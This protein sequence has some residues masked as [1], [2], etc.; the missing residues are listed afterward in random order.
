MQITK[1]SKNLIVN[2]CHSAYFKWTVM[3][4]VNK[5]GYNPFCLY[6]MKYEQIIITG[7]M[8]HSLEIKHCS[9]Y[10]YLRILKSPN[11]SIKS[12]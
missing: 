9:I 3:E 11:L 5:T 4:L 8:L 12:T 7:M 10:F 6:K 2:N 1:M